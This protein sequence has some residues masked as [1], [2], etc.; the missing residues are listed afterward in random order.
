M[1]LAQLVITS[2]LAGS[3]GTKDTYRN[4]SY[5]PILD[6][7]ASNAD[8]FNKGQQIGQEY[9]QAAQKQ[10]DDLQARKLSVVAAN[11]QAAHN[12]AALTQAQFAAQKAGAEAETAQDAVLEKTA[13]QNQST[14]LASAD[15]YD[16]GLTDKNAPKARLAQGMTWDELMASPFKEKMTS[17]LMI[18]DGT[19]QVY[20]E[21]LGRTK[22]VPTYSVL[23]PDV[24]IKLNEDTVAR[25]EK[26]NPSFGNDLYKVS[27]GNVQLPLTQLVTL[28]HQATSVMHAEATLQS[29][30]DSTDALAKNL[31][32][33]GDVEGKLAAAARGNKSVWKSLSEFENGQAHGGST[34][35]Q[36]QRILQSDGGDAIFK[37][38]GTDRD[39][40]QDY[41]E[42]YNN[43]IAS[44]RKLA[45]EGG[46]G[47]KA[48]MAQPQVKAL[49]DSIKN[50][51]NL[52]ASDKTNLLADV[53]APD[54]DG[55]IHMAQGQ[56]E[57]LT[58][59]LDSTV[60]SNKGIAERNLLAQ[61][62]P[63]QMQKSASNIIEGDVNQ[64]TKIASMRGNARTNLVNALHD[65]AV[66]RGLDSTQYT[67]TAL[68]NKA[69]TQQDYS[70][71]KKG[72][73]G[74]QIASF[75]TLVGHIQE[76]TNLSKKLEGKTIGLTNSPWMNTASD[77]IAKQ[78]ANDPDWTAYK[79]SLIPV[80]NEYAN[81]LAAGYSPKEEDAAMIR[82]VM[83]P[84]ETPARVLSALKQLATTAD[85]RLSNMGQRYL[86]TM[87]TTNTNLLTADSRNTFKNLGIPSKTDAVSQPIPRGWQGGNATKITPAVLNTIFEATDRDPVKAGQIAKANGWLRPN[88]TSY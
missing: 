21:H 88:G 4:G 48:P 5:G 1:S 30:A 69:N 77:T 59:R 7:Q 80:Q 53:P 72:S 87:Q 56:G 33:T 55:N 23:N 45:S 64:I 2:A 10:Q 24:K 3:F 82:Q 18:Q 12:Y 8:A 35:D 34:A 27:G 70:G 86:N 62:D 85:V 52:E 63:A 25:M 68:D 75:N 78:F 41:I 42:S 54:K 44:A 9:S 71:N 13:A 26:I 47:E 60:A 50:N 51:P 65:E 46:M 58:A 66:N 19:R 6:R 15:D 22:L 14:T 20:D 17:Q 16:H 49:V 81:L 83:D 79:A 38:L 11:I 61:G 73:T 39:R 29:L 67:Q 74:A 28:N 37:A 40:V 76:A 57:K 31:G 32:I 36:L 43:R 84:H